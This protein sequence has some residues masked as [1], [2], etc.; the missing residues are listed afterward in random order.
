MTSTTTRS[1]FSAEHIPVRRLTAADR[2][3]CS[4]LAVSRDWGTEDAKWELLFELG[5]VYGIEDPGGELIA[6]SVLT[7]YGADLAAVSMVLVAK[8]H[9][10]R[11]FGTRVVRHALEQADGSCVTL[12]AT[13]PGRPL[14]EKLGFRPFGTVEAHLG[15]FDATGASAG[16]SEP[17]AATDYAEIARLDRDAY[18]ADRA[19]LMARL[20]QLA[21]RIRVLR[22]ED[23]KLAGY[24][25]TWRNGETTVVGPVVAPDV[26]AARDLVT[27]LAVG[28]EGP[29][30]MD[31]DHEGDDLS[32]WACGHGLHPTY[33]CTHMAHGRQVPMDQSRLHAPLMCALG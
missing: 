24:G 32:A 6:T 18:G 31:I 27:D 23:G 12:H 33:S 9:E 29:V 8:S 13:Q 15:V 20:P 5:E 4:T 14:Y 7:R 1:G 30:R 22:A 28:V 2:A 16:R 19:A 10:R 25:A 3:R 26:A 11:G 21:Q 17:A